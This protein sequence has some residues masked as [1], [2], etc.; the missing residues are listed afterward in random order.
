MDRKGYNDTANKQAFGANGFNEI[1]SAGATVAVSVDNRF[2][3]I[4]ATTD[5]VFNFENEV[6]NGIKTATGYSLLEGNSL[7]GYFKNIV[8]TSGKIVVYYAG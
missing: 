1:T 4:I 3:T 5:A 6:E 2:A 7:Y 8:V